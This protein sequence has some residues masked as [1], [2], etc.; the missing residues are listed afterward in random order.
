MFF[1]AQ[2]I[3]CDWVGQIVKESAPYT[4][5]LLI[6]NPLLLEMSK[7]ISWLC[8]YDVIQQMY[9]GWEGLNAISLNDDCFYVWGSLKC[10]ISVSLVFNP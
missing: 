7:N 10:F 8:G 3:K 5:K 2:D 9:F 4:V 1:P 6:A